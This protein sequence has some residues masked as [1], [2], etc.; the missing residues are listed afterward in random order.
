MLKFI[1]TD[2]RRNI[3][4]IPF[5]CSVF[6]MVLMFLLGP[7]P[8]SMGGNPNSLTVISAIFRGRQLWESSGEYSAQMIFN[9][10]MGYRW[11]TII[12]P[13]IVS[14]PGIVSFCDEYASGY[15]R[16]YMIRMSKKSYAIS[17]AVSSWVTGILIAILSVMFFA[18][19]VHI[20]F[21][22]VSR[23]P[24]FFDDINCYGSF[25]RMANMYIGDSATVKGRV[26]IALVE[27][28]C[29]AI[30]CGLY[31]ILSLCIAVL[32]KNKFLSLCIPVIVFYFGEKINNAYDMYYLRHGVE[33]PKYFQLFFVNQFSHNLPTY[34]Y[35][36]GVPVWVMM[37]YVVALAVI[38][39]WTFYALQCRGYDLGT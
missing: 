7:C 6:L 38:L 21:P 34:A 36:L 31:S 20:I 24:G 35:R 10:F 25:Y 3:I 19:L 4:S 11:F 30:T 37:F 8:L 15:K 18:L 9:C 28:S 14:L 1:Y 16:F 12:L 26:W 5:L 2:L 27:T 13:L 17:K 33:L 22:D 39:V 32:V 23:Y 29:L